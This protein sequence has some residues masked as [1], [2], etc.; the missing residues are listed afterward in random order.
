MPP[1]PP[2]EKSKSRMSPTTAARWRNANTENA[3]T[4]AVIHRMTVSDDASPPMPRIIDGAEPGAVGG[5]LEYAAVSRM[6]VL[7]AAPDAGPAPSS[8]AGAPADPAGAVR[9][10]DPKGAARSSD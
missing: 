6:P 5:A 8:V 1:K 10:V 9:C 2:S 3:D 4:A 7:D